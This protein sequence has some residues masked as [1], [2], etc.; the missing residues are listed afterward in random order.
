MHVKKWFQ[1]TFFRYFL[2][3]FIVF[4]LSVAGMFLLFRAHLVSTLTDQ[5]EAQIENDLSSSVARLSEEINSLYAI[6]TQVTQ[7]VDV[8]MAKYSSEPYRAPLIREEL[9]KYVV[10]KQLIQAIGYLDRNHGELYYYSLK[11][12]ISY[13]DQKVVIRS[14]NASFSFCPDDYYT[15][16]DNRLIHLNE[17]G[18]SRFIYIPVSHS[19]YNYTVFFVLDNGTLEEACQTMLSDTVVNAALIAPDASV[20]VSA[21]AAKMPFP[22][23]D[24]ENVHLSARFLSG[25]RLAAMYSP[26]TLD[27]RISEALIAGI[28]WYIMI[29]IAG[30]LLVFMCTFTTYHPLHR[31]ASKF[32]GPEE[33]ENPNLFNR[34]DRA[35]EKQITQ[36]DNLSFRI[37]KYRTAMQKM[38]LD[39]MLLPENELIDSGIDA[40]IY[41]MLPEHHFIAAVAVSDAADEKTP[42]EADDHALIIKKEETLSVY[43][44]NRRFDAFSSHEEA[45][46][47]LAEAISDATGAKI[48][49]SDTSS[50]AMDI[51]SLA[52]QAT[53]ALACANDEQK[54][55]LYQQLSAENREVETNYQYPYELLRAFSEH[56]KNRMFNEAKAVL[57]D[58][59]NLLSSVRAPNDAMPDFFIRSVLIDLL[60]DLAIQMDVTKIKFREYDELYFK[61][62]YQSRS[63]AFKDSREEIEKLFGDMLDV[64]EKQT[65]SIFPRAETIQNIVRE[66]ISNPDFC[67]SSLYASFDI[68]LAY[69]SHLFKKETGENFSDYL[70][71][72]RYQKACELLKES[73]LSVDEVSLAV[74]YIHSSSFR[75]KFKQET[76]V[77]PTEYIADQS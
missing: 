16:S 33:Q 49:V 32:K 65:M 67:I 30:V 43:L 52:E 58:L 17:K 50:S 47:R 44:I 15:Y 2:S 62:L 66:N 13:K 73:S 39:S 24:N 11:D 40:D 18:E 38:L 54:V 37:E 5:Y 46:L 74:G 27:S 21:G 51:P 9:R 10:G 68:S 70:W 4:T 72:A 56:L 19:F 36:N 55:V 41:F 25:Y 57:S 28:P 6:H 23:I 29:A 14:V 75:R 26:E 20:S 45:L 69:M 59:M 77:S 8:M 61:A 48:G 7:N 63:C 22:S 1:A 35:I 64:F 71:K 42:F 31:L 34:L 76:G 3:Y 60:S 53:S 12:Y